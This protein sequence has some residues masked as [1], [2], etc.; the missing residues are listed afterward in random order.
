MG[1]LRYIRVT[2]QLGQSAVRH[3]VSHAFSKTRYDTDR[4]SMELTTQLVA[5]TDTYRFLRAV[6]SSNKPSGSLPE[7]AFDDKSLQMI[8]RN[9]KSND[10]LQPLFLEM[11][12]FFLLINL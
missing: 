11:V 7:I 1:Y 3:Y 10:R 6:K 5:I 8:N 2:C 12:G 9:I 4:S